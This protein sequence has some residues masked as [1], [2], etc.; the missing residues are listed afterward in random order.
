M[1]FG[2]KTEFGVTVGEG[3]LGMKIVRSFVDGFEPC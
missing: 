1:D 3:C 2:V